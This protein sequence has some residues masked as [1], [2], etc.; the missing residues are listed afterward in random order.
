MNQ[1]TRIIKSLTQEEQDLLCFFRPLGYHTRLQQYLEYPEA[2][3]GG[4]TIPGSTVCLSATKTF[5]HYLRRFVSS[6]HPIK[7][8]PEKDL[9]LHIENNGRFFV[10]L[11][12]TGEEITKLTEPDHYIFQYRCFLQLRRFWNE[13]REQCRVPAV[14]SPALVRGFPASAEYDDLLQQTLVVASQVIFV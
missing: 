6:F 8:L 5:R 3:V 4:T 2:F 7:L 12:E 14:K 11:G 10:R 13:L 1:Q 9:W